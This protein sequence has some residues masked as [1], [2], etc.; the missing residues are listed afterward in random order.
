MKPTQLK[1]RHHIYPQTER[2]HYERSPTVQSLSGCSSC[3][4][5]I[6]DLLTLLA[7]PRW[8]CVWAAGYREEV[9]EHSACRCDHYCHQ[10]WHLVIFI[11]LRAVSAQFPARRMIITTSRHWYYAKSTLFLVGIVINIAADKLIMQVTGALWG[12]GELIAF[13]EEKLISGWTKAED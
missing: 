9:L 12:K 3:A 8:S 5:Q 11:R 10:H 2:D 1:M 13:L 4:Q 7:G 6:S